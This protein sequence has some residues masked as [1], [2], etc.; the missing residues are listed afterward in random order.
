MTKYTGVDGSTKTCEARLRSLTLGSGRRRLKKEVAQKVEVE[1]SL[2]RKP[3]FSAANQQGYH[4][5]RKRFP[6]NFHHQ[7]TESICVLFFINIYIILVYSLLYQQILLYNQKRPRNATHFPA[8]G[9]WCAPS[10]ILQ[11]LH[12]YLY[13]NRNLMLATP[14][15]FLFPIPLRAS[16]S[17]KTRGQ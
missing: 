13:T 7:T 17:P 15:C 10:T 16:L 1:S 5:C 9:Y 11:T 12:I 14:R 3:S 6:I 8:L 4:F 2:L